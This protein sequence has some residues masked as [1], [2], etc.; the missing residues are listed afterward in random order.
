M[1]GCLNFAIAMISAV[2]GDPMALHA[3]QRAVWSRWR[4]QCEIHGPLS[5]AA[6]GGGR[7]ARGSPVLALGAPARSSDCWPSTGLRFA[8]R[9]R[10]FG[11]HPVQQN[12]RMP[13]EIG[14]PQ[15]ERYRLH[16]FPAKAARG[17]DIADTKA[18]VPA[19]TESTKANPGR[20][21][22]FIVWRGHRVAPGDQWTMG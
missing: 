12:G 19:C 1:S 13:G 11:L 6:R 20:R 17:K 4:K 14:T 16:R 3:G 8:G 21:F 7:T 5:D 22:C 18:V 2:G 10:A 9:P 15:S